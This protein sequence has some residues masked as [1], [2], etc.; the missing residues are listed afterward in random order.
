MKDAPEK[1]KDAPEKVRLQKQ[2]VWVPLPFLRRAALCVCLSGWKRQSELRMRTG[3]WGRDL[4]G[5]LSISSAASR[6]PALHGNNPS[7]LVSAPTACIS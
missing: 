5:A 3:R 6:P 4:A 7:R 1:V 2:E